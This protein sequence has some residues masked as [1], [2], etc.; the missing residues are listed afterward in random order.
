MSG[1]GLITRLSLACHTFWR[2]TQSSSVDV[3]LLASLR[4]S[5]GS[6]SLLAPL[7]SSR[8]AALRIRDDLGAR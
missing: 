6:K 3:P 5:E 4:G 7:A 2:S 8:K 1:S